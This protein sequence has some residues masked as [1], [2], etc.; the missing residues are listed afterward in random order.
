MGRVAGFFPSG[1]GGNP[2]QDSRAGQGQRHPS[3][4]APIQVGVIIHFRLVA[5]LGPVD[6]VRRK[7]GQ[8]VLKTE[9][10]YA[11]A[12]QFD[13]PPGI[14]GNLRQ[15]RYRVAVFRELIGLSSF[16]NG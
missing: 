11:V 2:D 7:S 6:F 14:N 16:R 12:V 4:G 3:A 8:G 1:R 13:K 9:N 5:N 10:R 15:N